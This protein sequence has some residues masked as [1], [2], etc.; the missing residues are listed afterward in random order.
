[1]LQMLFGFFNT[2]PLAFDNANGSFVFGGGK[3]LVAPFRVDPQI[4]S[5]LG[6]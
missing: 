1:M 5:E 6:H 3:L 4:N 2:M